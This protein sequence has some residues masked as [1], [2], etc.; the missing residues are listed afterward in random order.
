MSNSKLIDKIS[1]LLYSLH[2][3]EIDRKELFKRLPENYSEY[4][5]CRFPIYTE[6]R[7]E[8]LLFQQD[9]SEVSG[10]TE[11]AIFCITEELRE[12]TK[13]KLYG[14][15]SDQTFLSFKTK[16]LRKLKNYLS[17]LRKKVWFKE[18]LSEINTWAAILAAGSSIIIGIIKS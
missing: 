3:V 7:C 6:C 1:S 13:I 5:N 12:S 14:Y 15:V 9:A 18:H 4:D 16:E 10:D 8:R 11:G 2:N 17:W